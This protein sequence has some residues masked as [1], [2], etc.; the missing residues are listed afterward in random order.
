MVFLSRVYLDDKSRE[1]MRLLSSPEFTHGAV[2]SAFAGQRQRRLWRVDGLAG[3]CCLLVLSPDTPDFAQLVQR[4]GFPGETSAWLTKPYELL[5]DRLGK[6][7][8]WQFRLKANP[9]R[10]VPLEQGSR[11]KVMAHVT[12]DQQKEWLLSRAASN[13]F[14]LEPDAFEV[15]H[16]QWLRFHK[17]HGH[18]VTLRTATFEGRLTIADVDKFRSALVQGIGRAKAYGCGLMTI[19]P[20]KPM[21]SHG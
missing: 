6:G 11:G 4:Y 16:T 13:G 17:G 19:A 7:Q 2:E 20:A 15:V 3:R 21:R 12:T 9:V 18:E 1:T 10:S 14:A 8:P 5:L